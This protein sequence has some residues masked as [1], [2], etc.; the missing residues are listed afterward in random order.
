MPKNDQAH[1]E[2]VGDNKKRRRTQIDVVEKTNLS[3]KKSRI[4]VDEHRNSIHVNQTAEKTTQTAEDRWKAFETKVE[5]FKI[6]KEQ[7][8][9]SF[10]FAFVE[11]ALVK[12][13][14]KGTWILLDEINLASAETL[15][16]LSSI[17]DNPDG[18]LSLTEKGDVDVLRR[19]PNFRIFAAMNPATDVGKRI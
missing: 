2:L 16:R 9:S 3:N 1:A 19:H 17:L 12:A 15:Q 8:E 5:K 7:V 6:Q 10:A 14:Q 4:S 11:G 13:L 18:T